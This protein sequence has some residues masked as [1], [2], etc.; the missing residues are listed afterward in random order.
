MEDLPPGSGPD[1]LFT[2]L[3]INVRVSQNLKKT[4]NISAA[5]PWV[6]VGFFA[7]PLYISQNHESNFFLGKI[8]QGVR[9]ERIRVDQVK[10][11]GFTKHCHTMSHMPIQSPLR[12]Q[13]L[14]RKSSSRVC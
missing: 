6:A 9:V 11:Q 5:R 4:T 3:T 14:R 1:P 8:Q 7:I 2:S 10:N 13:A 12:L